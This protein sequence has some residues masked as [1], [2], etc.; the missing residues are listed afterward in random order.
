MAFNIEFRPTSFED[1][2]GNVSV[3][4]SLKTLLQQ[5]DR[6]HCYLLYGKTGCGKT[7]LARMIANSIGCSGY[8][9]IEINSS[10]NRGI[11]TARDIIS[12]MQYKPL[13]GEVKVYILDEVHQATKD[14]QNGILKALEDA[15]GHVYFI[16]CTTEPEKLLPTIRN[17]CVQFQLTILNSKQLRRLLLNVCKK[18][19]KQVDE[20]IIQAIIE[21]CEGVPRQALLMLQQVIDI[22]DI[23]IAIQSINLVK[24]NEKQIIDLCK[25]LV[26]GARWSEIAGILKG[27]KEEPETIR[28]AVLA[29]LSSVA[30]NFSNQKSIVRIGMLIE[31][32]SGNYYDSGRAGL[33]LSC[34][35]SIFIE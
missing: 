27:L 26:N 4:E 24:E 6:P 32:F 11:D 12:Q 17:R 30:C 19:G 16:L 7:T 14:F 29:Y 10:N 25:A 31:N 20:A 15:P 13:A 8:D 33:V 34:I 3:V 21:N 5:K 23:D 35:R 22:Q 1:F 28:R 2:I 18:V 9:M